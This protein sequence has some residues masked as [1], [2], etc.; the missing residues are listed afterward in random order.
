MTTIAHNLYKLFE[1]SSKY[2]RITE[3]KIYTFPVVQ[4]YAASGFE[5]YLG[6]A[7]NI[8]NCSNDLKLRLCTEIGS[9]GV[10]AKASIENARW[11]R[12]RQCPMC[13]FARS[14]KIRARLFKAFSDFDFGDQNS[15][16]F[17]TLTLQNCPLNKLRETILGMNSAWDKFSRR[18]TFPVTGYL[19]SLEV[20]MQRD[21]M[22]WD[23]KKNTG[24]P[25]RSPDDQLMAHPHFHILLRTRDGFDR[26]LKDKPW[27]ISQWSSAL[28]ADY[29][30]SI[31]IKKIRP[32][33]CNFTD[34]LLEVAKYT[35][36]PSEFSDVRSPVPTRKQRPGVPETPKYRPHGAEWLYGVTEQLHNL[37][38]YRLGGTFAKILTQEEIDRIDDSVGDSNEE[39]QV[40]NLIR[41]IWNDSAYKYDIQSCDY[42]DDNDDDDDFDGDDD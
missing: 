20:T 41:L 13:Q 2:K 40:G 7:N 12:C 5:K 22:P 25:T 42:S 18:R 27:L 26:H 29:L 30:P 31:D 10:T 16:S 35:V 17:L 11:C 4:H 24:P 14:S 37:R 34:T 1:E 3:A 33:S 21:R 8:L 28:R 6:Y 15:Y 36:K 38:A 23:K 39:S 19:R 32:T 9:E